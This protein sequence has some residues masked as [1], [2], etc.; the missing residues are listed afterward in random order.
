MT[1]NGSALAVDGSGAAAAVSVTGGNKVKLKGGVAVFKEVRVA[2]ELPGAY[3]LRVQ[4]ASRKVRGAAGDALVGGGA[5]VQ[6]CGAMGCVGCWGGLAVS[7]CLAYVYPWYPLPALALCAQVALQ[8]GTLQLS[9]AP[10]NVVVGLAV[11]VPEALE[12][13]CQAGS[14][15]GGQ[16]NFQPAQVACGVSQSLA[17]GLKLHSLL[18]IAAELHVS[19]ETEDGR[20]VP[21]DVA[22]SSLSLKLTP[23]GEGQRLLRQPLGWWPMSWGMAA[24]LQACS[25]SGTANESQATML[26]R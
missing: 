3:A 6:A 4:S 5:S 26:P 22:S 24:G 18:P 15:G 14:A 12:E 17:G 25:T 8:D 7:A 19:V 11:A 13:G 2:A 10:Q 16:L 9:M 1:L 23:P 21:A 20:P